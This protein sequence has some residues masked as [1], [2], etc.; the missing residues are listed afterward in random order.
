MPA[1]TFHPSAPKVTKKEV[2]NALKLPQTKWK[3]RLVL[4]L[5]MAVLPFMKSI[6][7][8]QLNKLTIYLGGILTTALAS[9]GIDNES[10]A[11]LIASVLSGLVSLALLALELFM[12][13]V[14]FKLSPPPK[15]EAVRD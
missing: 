2:G 15:A 3:G 11:I 4:S 10:N 7:L 1:D 6:L 12:A 13:W 8:R 9:Y 14:G 5:V